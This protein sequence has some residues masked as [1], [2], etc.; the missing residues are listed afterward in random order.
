MT[1]GVASGYE[2]FFAD[3]ILLVELGVVVVIWFKD[4]GRCNWLC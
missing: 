1:L 4:F 2:L 3:M